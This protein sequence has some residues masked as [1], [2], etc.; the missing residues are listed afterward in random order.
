[1]YKT[2][3]KIIKYFFIVYITALELSKEKVLVVSY[4]AC[5]KLA[6]NVC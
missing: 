3:K 6:F 1:M 5:Y 2:I 4:P